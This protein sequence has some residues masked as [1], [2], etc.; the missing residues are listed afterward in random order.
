MEAYHVHRGGSGDER[1]GVLAE[2]LVLLV[3]VE[4]A[5]AVEEDPGDLLVRTLQGGRQGEVVAVQEVL[6]EGEGPLLH[7]ARGAGGVEDLE[8]GG[9]LGIH[10]TLLVLALPVFVQGHESGPDA[11]EAAAVGLT[12]GGIKYSAY[13]DWS[14]ERDG[15]QFTH[16][17][18]G[19]DGIVPQG[20]SGDPGGTLRLPV[21]RNEAGARVQLGRGGGG[22]G[23]DG[24]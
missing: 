16:E 7:L 11:A 13:Q 2:E 1:F 19:E 14:L 8:Q 15:V 17:A 12:H 20:E 6:Q 23:G 3:E 9:V 21:G 4:T 5:L 18:H 10:P 24:D 22:G